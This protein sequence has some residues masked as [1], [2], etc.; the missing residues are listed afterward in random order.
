MSSASGVVD[1]SPRVSQILHGLASLP[2]EKV[3]E[4]YDFVHFL[5]SRYA[6]DMPTGNG[7]LA[8][9]EREMAAFEGLS[10]ELQERYAGRAVAVYQGQIVA[11]GD[12]KLAVL[13]TVLA[14][15]GPVPCYIDWVKPSEPRRARV[16]SV[17]I[18]K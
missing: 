17:W 5:R 7:G 6:T 12:S 2:P 11:D 16:P 4:V 13:E 9:F 18:A 15:L 3:A 8:S 1:T 14:N 10:P